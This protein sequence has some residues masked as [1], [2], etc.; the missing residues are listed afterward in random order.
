[1]NAAWS[2][3]AVD[4][5]FHVFEA[6]VGQPGAR[7][8]PAYD[9]PL[10]AWQAAASPLGVTR[11]VLVQTS[12]MGTDNSALVAQLQR[13]PQALRGVAVVSPDA[14][15]AVLAPLHAAGVRGLRLNLAGVSHRLDAWS[16]ARAL[17]DAVAQLGWHVELHTDVGG[18][19]EV[20]AQLPAQVPVVIDHMGKPDTVAAHDP[21]VVAVRARARSAPVHVKLSGAYRLAGRDPGAL[22]R[23]WR[24]ELGGGALLWG[25]DWPCTNHEDQADYPR[26]LGALHDWVGE[27]AAQRALTDNPLA[28]YWGAAVQ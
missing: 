9:A 2:K 24:D 22:A 3:S 7:Y 19:P 21:T 16:A 4:S 15:L 27:V 11:G 25:S 8:V 20:L 1:M 18:L 5:H 12:F 13:H 26:L 14:G 23:L 28:L 10:Q 6:G 17:W